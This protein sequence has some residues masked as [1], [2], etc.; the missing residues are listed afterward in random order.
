MVYM[1]NAF[2]AARQSSVRNAASKSSN[3][4]PKPPRNVLSKYRMGGG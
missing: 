3:I 2:H 4:T 1:T